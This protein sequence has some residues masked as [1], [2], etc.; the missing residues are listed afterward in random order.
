MDR[1]SMILVK[2]SAPNPASLGV[3]NG[4]AQ[5]AMVRTP[6]PRPPPHPINASTRTH[7]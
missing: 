5:F 6:S 7:R 1:V 4:I 2:D 3:T